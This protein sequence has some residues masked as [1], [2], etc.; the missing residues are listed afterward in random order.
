[1]L[2]FNCISYKFDKIS[3]PK[4]R[5][6]LKNQHFSEKSTDLAPPAY[7]IKRGLKWKNFIIFRNF[8]KNDSL[9]GYTL[10]M[11]FLR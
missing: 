7:T 2:I 6:A 11:L 4:I 10:S 5:L 8:L 1:M 3:H 9:G